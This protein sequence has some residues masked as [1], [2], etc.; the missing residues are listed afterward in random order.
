MGMLLIGEPRPVGGLVVIQEA[1][2]A[3]P[4][5]A[6]QPVEAEVGD[7]IRDVTRNGPARAAFRTFED[8]RGIMIEALPR[9][10]GPVVESGRAMGWAFAEMPLAEDGGLVAAVLEEFGESLQPVVHGGGK[11]S[12]AI[13][14]VVSAGQD[15]GAAGRADGIGAE[16]VVEPDAALS[17]A[18]EVWRFVDAAAIAA[19]GMGR[20]VV[21]HDVEDV[22]PRCGHGHDLQKRGW[23]SMRSSGGVYQVLWIL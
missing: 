23:G 17:D 6:L 9:D 5:A 22:G 18:V 15:C 11:G 20:M 3:I 7:D 16:A 14:V 19:H 4:I 1:E 8:E 12:A 2:G 21:G 10:D 13:H